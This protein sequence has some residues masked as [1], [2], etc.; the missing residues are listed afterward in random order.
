[1]STTIADALRTGRDT[2]RGAAAP[3]PTPQLDT[4]VLL[5]SALECSASVLIAH[6]ERA[7]TADQERAFSRALERRAR[8]EPVAH[9]V[10]AREFWSL[11][12][13]VSPATLIPRPDTETLV[14]AAL[15]RIAVDRP[16]RVLDLGTGSGAIALAIAV[17]RPQSVIVATDVS[18]AA[19]AVARDN[20]QRHAPRRV[21]WRE[22]S[23][24]EAVVNEEP[25][26]VIVSNPPYVGDDDPHLQRGDLRFEPRGALCAGPD[27]LAD[28][29]MI[30]SGAQPFLRRDGTLLVE[31]GADQSDAVAALFHAAH[32]TQ[33]ACVSDLAGQPRVTLGRRV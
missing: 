32:F 14:D 6:A 23:W 8:G 20:A 11:Q 2:L 21:A 22:G 4:R 9:I 33:V 29:R 3:S 17:E 7:L 16:V 24:W 13:K 5:C 19:L 30:V 26:D 31:H 1:M 18:A 10:G 15:A 27:G 12:L 25:F 28:L